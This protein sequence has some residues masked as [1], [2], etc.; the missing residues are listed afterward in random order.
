MSATCFT[1]IYDFTDWCKK[2]LPRLDILINNA[3][4]TVAH[5]EEFYDHLRIDGPSSSKDISRALDRTY[6]PLGLLDAHGQ[7][8]DLRP[9]NSWSALLADVLIRELLQVCVYGDC[10]FGFCGRENAQ[11]VR[12]RLELFHLGGQENTVTE[13]PFL[14][15]F[16]G[17]IFS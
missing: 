13:N 4:Q 8:V 12:L 6:F 10:F 16:S 5:P 3:A 15:A 9:D 17:Q 1:G 2:Q 11:N 14:T 7:Q